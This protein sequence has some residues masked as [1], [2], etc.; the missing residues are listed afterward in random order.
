[1]A[2]L[3][4]TSLLARTT[5]AARAGRTDLVA[6]SKTIRSA[7]ERLTWFSLFFFAYQALVHGH[8]LEGGCHFGTVGGGGGGGGEE[9]RKKNRADFGVFQYRDLTVVAVAAPPPWHCGIVGH[10]VLA[11]VLA[12]A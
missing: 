10:T 4:R 9:N 7:M 2:R 1:M 11:A 6:Y 5:T 12:A 8:G 3:S